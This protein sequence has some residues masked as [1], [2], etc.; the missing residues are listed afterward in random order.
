MLF[1][2]HTAEWQLNYS[3]GIVARKSGDMFFFYFL[4][5]LL[6]ILSALLFPGSTKA[7][8]GWGKN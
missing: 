6:H 3:T 5:I 4:F 8:I 2:R 7:Y 1:S